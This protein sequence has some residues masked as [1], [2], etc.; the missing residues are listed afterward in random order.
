MRQIEKQTIVIFHAIVLD[1]CD[2][3]ECSKTPTFQ[4]TQN[5]VMQLWNW[6]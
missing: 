4:S 6:S 3:E 5:V 2:T 1:A